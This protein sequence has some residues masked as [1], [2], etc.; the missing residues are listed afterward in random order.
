MPVCQAKASSQMPQISPAEQLVKS[1]P[2]AG[3]FKKA[4]AH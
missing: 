2:S 3:L 4:A 1:K